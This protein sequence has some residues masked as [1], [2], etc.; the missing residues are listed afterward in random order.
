MIAFNPMA[1]ILHWYQLRA[2]A[3]ELRTKRRS[4]MCLDCGCGEPN[5]KHGDDRH[6]TM[7][8]VQQA[9]EASEITQQ[10]ATQNIIKALEGSMTS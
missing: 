2:L 1:Q 4:D 7:D 3:L 8:D 10:E 5:E 6:L 9:A